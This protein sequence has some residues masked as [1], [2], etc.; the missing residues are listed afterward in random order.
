M[1]SMSDPR[2]CQIGH[3]AP[4]WLVNYADLMTELVCFFIILYA[5]TAALNKDL[6]KAKKEVEQAM[7]QEQVA[8]EVK[9]TKDGMQ[10]TL[11]E[12]GENIFF[13]SGSSDLS[14]RM[15]EILA[16]IAPT[17][18]TLA[19]ESHDIVVEGHTDDVPIHNTHFS[20]NWELST[21]R[22]T[23]VVQHLIQSQ[24]LP[25][26]HMAA[27]G[28]GEYHPLVANNTDEHRSANRRVVFFV[29]NKPPDYSKG[30][31]KTKVSKNAETPPVE[32][33]S[34]LEAVTG[35]LPEEMPSETAASAEPTTDSA[36]PLPQEAPA[37]GQ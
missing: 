24:G 7:K 33:A 1:I 31:K 32:Q 21:A 13:E 25:A 37:G 5:M 18:N 27:I 9:V 30:D 10:I 6:Q 28:Y 23:S 11:Q 29:K 26:K 15:E 4:P 36:L 14:P 16:K 8:G 19:K 2:V 3:P 12:K 34:A 17:L 35:A 22:A 20:S